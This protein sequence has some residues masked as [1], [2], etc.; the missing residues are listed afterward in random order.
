MS[1][2]DDLPASDVR[3]PFAD[4][5][6]R[7]SA[8]APFHVFFERPDEISVELYAPVGFDGQSP[9]DRDELYIIA[10]GTGIFSRGKERVPFGPGDL[11]YVPA[12]EPH[13]F[14][15]FTEGFSTWVIFYGPVRPAPELAP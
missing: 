14:E 4:A 3:V 6:A 5:F 11:L 7:L 1:A 9:H 10:S 2:T 15:E 12:Y 8:K 13:R